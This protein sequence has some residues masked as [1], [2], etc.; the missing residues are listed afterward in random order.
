VT[1]PAGVIRPITARRG[2]VFG[3]ACRGCPLRERCTAS[4]DE[5][6]LR[7]TSTT[8]SC[9]SRDWADNQQLRDIY[10][11]HRPMVERSIA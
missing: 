11:Q 5:R 4:P 7:C 6:T 2:V 10:R 1:C 3:A 9:A 8:R